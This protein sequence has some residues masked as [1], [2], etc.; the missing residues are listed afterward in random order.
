MICLW[1]QADGF[2]TRAAWD[3]TQQRQIIKI[4]LTD[5]LY[6]FML[7]LVLIK[8]TNNLNTPNNLVIV[9]DCAF[10]VLAFK[11]VHNKGNK[12]VIKIIRL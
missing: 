12:K 4:M 11:Y 9:T 10:A 2:Y 5:E 7:I 8:T 1:R 6:D 3:G